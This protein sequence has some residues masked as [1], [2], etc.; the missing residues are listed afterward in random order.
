MNKGAREEVESR[1]EWLGDWRPEDFDLAVMKKQF[2][3]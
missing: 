1:L 3:R 2:D